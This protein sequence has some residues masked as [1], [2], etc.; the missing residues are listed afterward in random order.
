M[1]AIVGEAQGDCKENPTANVHL[2]ASE[3]L[4]QK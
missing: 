4:P 2:A 1:H 3:G